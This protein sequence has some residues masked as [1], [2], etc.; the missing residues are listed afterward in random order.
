MLDIQLF[1]LNLGWHH[2]NDL[3]LHLANVLLLFLVLRRMAK[4]PW[5][6][7]FV[8][9]LFAL[10]PLHVETFYNRGLPTMSLVTTNKRLKSLT[11]PSAWIPGMRRLI[12]AG[13]PSTVK[14]VIMS[15]QFGMLRSHR[16]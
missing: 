9:A 12:T 6:S 10:L 16:D 5:K 14:L 4:A 3:L 1:G 13:A 7:V 15:R 11:K 2:L 8:A